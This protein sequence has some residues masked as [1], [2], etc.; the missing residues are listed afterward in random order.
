MPEMGPTKGVRE[1]APAKTP[2]RKNVAPE[3]LADLDTQLMLRVQQ[4]DREAA[5]T[6]VRRN[7]E[8]IGRYIARLLGHSRSA[9]DLTQDVFL[10]ALSRAERYEP[11]AKVTTWLYRIATNTTLNYLK[12]TGKR[13]PAAEPPE[14]PHE[15][16]D[17]RSRTPDQHVGADEVRAQ[18]AEA[19]RELPVNQRVALLL[20]E[21]EH[22]SY[23]QIA[24]IL[25]VSVEAV[26]S[27]L[28]R[29]RTTLRRQLHELM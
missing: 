29:A 24:Q 23:E 2:V 26:R 10:R 25:G 19:V 16:P 22:C 13:Q 20:F 17:H 18:V 15:P 1:H 12:R 6:L 28:L 9:E 4:G 7:F 11:T 27:L 5:G 21:Y 14:G 8:R 3:L